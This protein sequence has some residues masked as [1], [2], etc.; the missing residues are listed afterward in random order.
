MV[1]NLRNR[2]GVV[3]VVGAWALVLGVGVAPVFGQASNRAAVVAKVRQ[4]TAFAEVEGQGAGG[5]GTA[6]C[7][8]AERGVFVTNNH[9]I[10]AANP[11]GKVTLIVRP[12]SPEQA[13]YPA[14]IVAATEEPDL[15]ILQIT[16]GKNLVAL[17]LE[18]TG[19][20]VETQ[21]VI[22]FGYPLGR[23]VVG[24]GG[25]GGGVPDVS[26][27][28]GT[29]SALRMRDG[30]LDMIQ[31]DANVN[32]GNSGG[33]LVTA[34]G[35]VAG[36]IVSGF[37][38]QRINFAIPVDKVV[39]M[40]ERPHV[41]FPPTQISYANREKPTKF[42]IEVVSFSRRAVEP[43]IT[44]TISAGDGDLREFKPT[45][46]GENRY[47]VTAVPVPSAMQPGHV[48]VA[49]T[50]GS[51]GREVRVVENVKVKA[52]GKEYRL[53][54]L[55]RVTPGPGGSVVLTNGDEIRGEVVL[56]GRVK[57]D[58]WPKAVDLN[59]A[60]VS[61]V[62]VDQAATG[63]STVFVTLTIKVEG[64]VVS[65]LERGIPLTGVPASVAG[66]ETDLQV[67]PPAIGAEARRS[68][69]SRVGQM[70]VG[71]DGRFLVLHM[72][73]SGKLAVFDVNR[74]QIVKSIDVSGGRVLF[75]CN[76]E[77]LFIV[78]LKVE[79]GQ[80]QTEPS[81]HIQRWDLR[82]LKQERTAPLPS[83]REDRNRED[84]IVPRGFAAGRDPAAPLLLVTN[85]GTLFLRPT[86]LTAILTTPDAE[87]ERGIWERSR[88]GLNVRGSEDGSLFGLWFDGIVPSGLYTTRM[89]HRTSFVAQREDDAGFILPVLGGGLLLTARGVFDRDLELVHESLEDWKLIADASGSF[90]LGIREPGLFDDEPRRRVGLFAVGQMPEP[91]LEIPELSEVLIRSAA[92]EQDDDSDQSGSEGAD[93]SG[94]DATDISL[95]EDQR[96]VLIP[97]AGV[98]VSVSPGNRELVL[99][100]L[101]VG[102]LL[103]GLKAAVVVSRPSVRVQPGSTW[104]YEPVLYGGAKIST[105]KL[106]SG[107]AGMSVSPAG[108][109][110]WAV[111]ADWSDAKASVEVELGAAGLKPA[112]HR[113]MVY[114]SPTPAVG[115]EEGSN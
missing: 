76:R 69:P 97:A 55:R 31:T 112:V 82:T 26:V 51:G 73:R 25:G 10:R 59:L 106:L 27:N 63:A 60:G 72:P 108:V 96:Y 115:S 105:A 21:E 114:R 38:Q 92:D 70:R 35:K 46:A 15:A 52:A 47:E 23:R 33:P 13:S 6:W 74:G 90:A 84:V 89:Q 54:E 104:T 30:K 75:D 110:S 20:L 62:L 36:V 65:R 66:D 80:R 8:D 103:E 91:L 43:E 40:L 85:E 94:A 9:V 48:R 7:V 19:K 83:L 3:S 79:A 18:E 86:S 12:N 29:I 95:G 68:L 67:L 88:R 45:K 44:M 101:D 39:A 100:R 50:R 107:P 56:P 109:L 37:L 71:G 87:S 11:S 5:T 14:R 93:E 32:P 99:R 111:P 16:G 113:F 2:S 77:K 17:E 1:V 58:L 4:A 28:A 81:F 49:L 78:D 61:N 102:Q 22:A 24:A 42:P 41:S 53:S 57:M 98:L 34:E 64:E